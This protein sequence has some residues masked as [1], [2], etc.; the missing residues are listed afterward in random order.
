M[1]DHLRLPESALT[2]GT[3]VVPWHDQWE[4]GMVVVFPDDVVCHRLGPYRTEPLARQ[5]AA[6][7][8][9]AADRTLRA[10]GGH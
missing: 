10:A 6:W 5:T 9:E 8:Q 2:V 7:L 1:T 4:V 3:F